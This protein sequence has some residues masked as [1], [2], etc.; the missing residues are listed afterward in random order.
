MQGCSVG[1][2]RPPSSGVEEAEHGRSRWHCPEFASGRHEITFCG[3][4]IN[5]MRF[6][7]A[8]YEEGLLKPESP[9]A[10]TPGERVALIVVRHPDPKRWDLERLAKSGAEEDRVLAEQGLADW[11]DAKVLKE[12]GRRKNIFVLE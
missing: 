7:E 6:I 10:L 11:A 8:R 5:A 2:Q 1:L 9:L 4:I 12:R 3:M